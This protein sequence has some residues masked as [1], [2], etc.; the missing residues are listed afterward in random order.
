MRKDDNTIIKLFE[1]KRIRSVWDEEREDYL[2]SVVDV[3]SV[4]TESFNPNDYWY[5][6]KI[7]LKKEEKS[8]LS[9]NCRQLKLMAN[10]GKYYSTDVLD[11]KGI[12]RLIES[13]PSKNAEPF[14]LWLASLGKERIDEVFNPE[15][16][17]NRAI[18][19][20]KKRGYSDDWIESRIKGILNRNKL[21]DA[22]KNHGIN[23]SI[24]FA[25]LTNEIYKTWSGM[26]AS[27]YKTYKGLRKESLRDNMTDLELLLTDIGEVTTRE[28]VNVKNPEGLLENKLIAEKGGK[29]AN[30]T[31]ENIEKILGKKIITEENKL[32]YKY[33]EENNNILKINIQNK[34]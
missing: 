34:E 12:L 29:I 26:K 31:R 25:V 18:S 20:Y 22:W 4:L 5:R 23:K 14:K 19:Y 2:F 1:G 17:I 7:R 33:S 27:E 6:L 11:T 13:V 15:L 30:D 10:D 24:D 8:E 9:T 16:A 32:S 3:I 28:L 21:T